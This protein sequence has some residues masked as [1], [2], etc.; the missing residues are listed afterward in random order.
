MKAIKIIGYALFCFAFLACEDQKQNTSEPFSLNSTIGNPVTLNSMVSDNELYFKGGIINLVEEGNQYE[1]YTIQEI[2]KQISDI[3]YRAKRIPTELFLKNKGVNGDELQ[4]AL[5]DVEGEQLF[6]FEFEEQ[7]KQDLVKKYLDENLDANI[8]Y[9][10]F[11]IYRDFGLITEKG[12]TIS[13]NYAIYEQSFHLAPYERLIISF[14]GVDPNE[15]VRLIYNDKLFGKG[16][17]DFAFASTNYV[18][19]NLKN[20]S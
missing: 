18:N 7:L 17:F 5:S 6:Y 12:D 2:T 11:E 4:E 14:S 1:R 15:E 20:P 8:A 13:S 3:K 19:N 9:L 10:S 16:R